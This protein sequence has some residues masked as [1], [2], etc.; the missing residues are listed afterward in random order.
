MSSKV[1]FMRLI[2]PL[3]AAAVALGL[4]MGSALPAAASCTAPCAYDTYVTGTANANLVAYYPMYE[5]SG[6][7]MNDTSG[8]GHNG[9]YTNATLGGVSGVVF[10]G[11]TSI[12]ATPNLNTANA[13]QILTVAGWVIDTEAGTTSPHIMWEQTS[14]SG[15]NTGAVAFDAYD[16]APASFPFTMW[17]DNN[18]GAGHYYSNHFARPASR[19]AWHHFVWEFD[20]F[21]TQGCN[22]AFL[23]ID[24][25]SQTASHDQCY[26]MHNIAF[27][28]NQP[29]YFGARSGVSFPYH[30]TLR[31][32]GIWTRA[33]TA[34][35]ISDL[36][37]ATFI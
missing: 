4:V 2:G 30:V 22:S 10:N 3:V 18:S 25:T 32:V 14:N 29:F 13:N 6:T 35:E 28:N 7:T 17:E 31:G 24:G 21:T 27:L 1:R 37:T 8:N 20:R 16:S 15:S 5:G 23:V 26:E 12:A 11:S 9:T 34:T 36:V 33:L 19:T